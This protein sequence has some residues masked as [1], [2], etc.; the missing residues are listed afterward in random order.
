[1]IQN[2]IPTTL[3]AD[4][5]FQK[6]ILASTFTIPI[7]VVWLYVVNSLLFLYASCFWAWCNIWSLYLYYLHCFLC[8]DNS[9]LAFFSSA[10]IE[11][12]TSH[13]LSR[14]KTELGTSPLSS[15]LLSQLSICIAIICCFLSTVLASLIVFSNQHLCLPSQFPRQ[16]LLLHVKNTLVCLLSVI[17]STFHDTHHFSVALHSSWLLLS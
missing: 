14:H 12:R 6:S 2:F 1:M 11:L 15:D 4:G 10:G 9:L 13:L 17:I 7:T 3:W 16:L 8:H 5:R